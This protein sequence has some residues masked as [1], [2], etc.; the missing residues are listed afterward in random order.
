MVAL[1]LEHGASLTYKS[2]AGWDAL[3]IAISNHVDAAKVL[4]ERGA[5]PNVVDREG[6]TLLI[7]AA[8]KGY[9]E[10]IDLLLEAGAHVDARGH[11]PPRRR[12]PG[13]ASALMISSSLY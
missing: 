12:V 6:D 10:S 7:V 2:R 11:A 8:A 5:D 9:P 3:G 1:L 13:D 4:L